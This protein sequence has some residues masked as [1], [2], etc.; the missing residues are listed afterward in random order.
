MLGKALCDVAILWPN[1]PLAGSKASLS[2]AAR[3]D[4]VSVL[5]YD[6]EMNRGAIAIVDA[7]GFK[8]IWGDAAKPS[9]AVLATLKVIGEAAKADVGKTQ[10]QLDR[11]SLPV[12]GQIEWGISA[13]EHP[14]CDLPGG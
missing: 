6:A 7:L 1:V 9:L 4:D 12:P 5:I 2:S 8:G 10:R 14:S 13:S 11:S 3:G